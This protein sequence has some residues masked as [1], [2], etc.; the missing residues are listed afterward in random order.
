MVELRLKRI[1]QIV[2]APLTRET[3]NVF[4]LSCLSTIGKN[5]LING[6]RAELETFLFFMFFNPLL[7]CRK[8]LKLRGLQCLRC[9]SFI[10]R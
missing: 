4:L 9:K 5:V 8:T 3:V 7:K 6:L 10:L 2:C 1:M